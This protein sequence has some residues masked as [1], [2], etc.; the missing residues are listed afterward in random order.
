MANLH[1]TL[2]KSAGKLLAQIAQEH[3]LCNLDPK[4][5][6]ETFTMSLNDLPVEMAIKLLSGE[7]VIEVEDDGV[8]VNVVSR[9]ENKHSDYP[10]PDFVDWYLFQ[11]KEIRRSGDR[12][13]LGLEELQRSISIH[14]GS[15]DFEFNYQAL[16]KFIIKNDI[17]EIEDIIDSDP[18]VENMRRMFK[19]SDAYLRKTYKLFNVFDFLEHTYPQQINPFNGCVPGT[20]YP[21]INRIEMK[22]KA[23]IEYDYELIE[24]TIREEDEGIKKHIEAAQD[25]EKELRNIIQP[26]DIKL[27][28]SAGWLDPNGFFYGLNGEISNMLHMNLADAIREKYK[29]EK[30]TD[31]GENPDRWLEEHGWVKIH[32]NWIL[33]SGYDESGFNRKDIPLTDCQK[34]SL[35]AYG[36]VCHKGILKIGYQKEA[37]PAAR[38]NIVDDIM[39]RKYFSL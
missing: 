27:N 3:L 28:Y 37:I 25:I 13:R 11:H 4:K 38:L 30:G 35:V 36:N 17:T 21:I 5:A 23:L 39:L 34:N 18:R 7:L 10:K 15:F 32:G 26:S 12:I 20:R 1:F 24:A 2:D 33:Y 31:I 22:L 9:D 19:L 16:G 14:R 29:V 6:I 8:N